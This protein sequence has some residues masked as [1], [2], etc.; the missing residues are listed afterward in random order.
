MPLVVV[1]P[2]MKRIMHVPQIWLGMVFNWGVWVGYAGVHESVDLSL[3]GSLYASAMAWTV[4][5]DTIY[6]HQDKRDD[7]LVGV[8]SAALYFGDNTKIYLT[9]LGV[10]MLSGLTLVGI[11]ANM[12]YP[13][14]LIAVLGSGIHL[15][16]QL[17]SVNLDDTRSCNSK[18]VSNQWLGLMIFLGLAAG[19]YFSSP[20]EGRDVDN[21]SGDLTGYRKK[22]S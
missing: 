10:V 9:G 19:R 7:R 12:P 8:N 22:S 5:Y 16:W 18:F 11:Q 1:Y 17:L 4:F 15:S 20:L 6:A 14:Y 13:Y 2:L 21:N 3:A